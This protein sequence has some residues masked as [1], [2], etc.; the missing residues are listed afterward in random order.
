MIGTGIQEFGTRIT[1]LGT[2]HGFTT[3]TITTIADS[4]MTII[5]IIRITEAVQNIELINTQT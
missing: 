4:I 3:G 2:D 1:V 5:I